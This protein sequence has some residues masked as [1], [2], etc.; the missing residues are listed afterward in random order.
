MR[1][2]LHALDPN[3]S[4]TLSEIEK[5]DNGTIRPGRQRTGDPA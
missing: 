4:I 3:G 5:L 1:Q 2:R